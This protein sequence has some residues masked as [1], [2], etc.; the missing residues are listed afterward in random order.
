MGDDKKDRDWRHIASQAVVLVLGLLGFVGSYYA[1][2]AKGVTE[3]SF[4]LGLTMIFIGYASQIIALL[5]KPKPDTTLNIQTLNSA[6]ILII[7]GIV[8][9]VLAMFMDF[10]EGTDFLKKIPK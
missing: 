6:K 10:L 5:I 9:I 4:G 2:F 8:I 3:A 1:V 7:G